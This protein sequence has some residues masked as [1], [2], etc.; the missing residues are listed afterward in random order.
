MSLLITTTSLILAANITTSVIALGTYPLYTFK[1]FSSRH[2]NLPFD[3]PMS[4]TS[5]PSPRIPSEFTVHV[6]ISHD[7]FIAPV[8]LPDLFTETSFPDTLWKLP[9]AITPPARPERTQE[10]MTNEM[11][12]APWIDVRAAV[13]RYILANPVAGSTTLHALAETIEGEFGLSRETTAHFTIYPQFGAVDW[14]SSLW[15]DVPLPSALTL[16][17]V[18][19]FD[20]L[21]IS[22]NQYVLTSEHYAPTLY[23]VLETKAAALKRTLG[24]GFMGDFFGEAAKY[25]L[26][27][28][29]RVE[30]FD[31]EYIGFSREPSIVALFRQWR[32]KFW[33]LKYLQS[34]VLSQHDAGSD[35]AEKLAER[36]K[37]TEMK[38]EKIR[39]SILALIRQ[40]EEWVLGIKGG[41]GVAELRD[42]DVEERMMRVLSQRAIIR[43][44]VKTREE[45]EKL[46]VGRLREAYEKGEKLSVQGGKSANTQEVKGE[47]DGDGSKETS[48][49]NEPPANG[50]DIEKRNNIT[51][52]SF[53][54]PDGTLNASQGTFIIESGVL[55]WGQIL[56]LYFAFRQQNLTQNAESIPKMLEGGTIRQ[57]VYTYKSAARNGKWKVGR[58]GS[59]CNTV[60]PLDPGAK[61][62]RVGWVI[63]HSD[64]DPMGVLERVRGLAGTGPGA[65]SNGNNHID[66]DVLYIGRYDW[67]HHWHHPRNRDFKNEFLEWSQAWKEDETPATEKESSEPLVTSYPGDEQ[68]TMKR[69]GYF[70]AMDASQFSR[71]F[72]A[73][74]KRDC[75]SLSEI[76]DPSRAPKVVERVFINDRKFGICVSDERTEYELAW[77]VFSGK[78]HEEHGA[79]ELVAIVYDARYEALEWLW[80]D[81]EH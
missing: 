6:F 64:I 68:Q 30:S 10:G 79:D 24:V 8:F 32:Q 57:Y 71:E 20:H 17:E 45:G 73:A 1:R 11:T 81:V 42:E 46:P 3:R 26:D 77:L 23:L 58:Y 51:T 39:G 14:T 53:R 33:V 48:L 66:K 37:D 31:R 41:E 49:E 13:G 50:E 78:K 65:I 7:P 19:Q 28:W 35:E 5:S 55:S 38:K 76:R 60:D 34:Q 44:W 70:I 12:N 43:E 63:Y 47:V 62:D 54:D 21:A 2:A 25:D 4:E 15:H 9:P 56:P 22:E 36:V 52:S 75:E 18:S 16:A 67:S 74:Y 69:G 29:R 61:K 72:V 27:T 80:H 40:W 59:S